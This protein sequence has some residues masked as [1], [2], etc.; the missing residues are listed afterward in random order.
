MSNGGLRTHCTGKAESAVGT[1]MAKGANGIWPS[2]ASQASEPSSHR[3][4]SILDRTLDMSI[5]EA[6]F[7]AA[8]IGESQFNLVQSA[9]LPH[10]ARWYVFAPTC[11]LMFLATGSGW[12]TVLTEPSRILPDLAWGFGVLAAGWLLTRFLRRRAW[13]NY[14]RLHN[15]V[16]G[17]VGP[18]GVEWKTEIT[19]SVLPWEKLLGFRTSKDLVLIF[20][21]P[22]CA[23]FFPRG[24]F[25]DEQEWSALLD[26]L[27]RYSKRL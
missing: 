21:S 2:V 16:S 18:H 7:S 4:F 17:R 22:R 5:K 13:K 25:A 11:I 1:A 14:V 3:A 19:S 8:V 27:S 12:R 10:W 9:L 26:V 24:F 23:F 20:Y 15:S 6:T